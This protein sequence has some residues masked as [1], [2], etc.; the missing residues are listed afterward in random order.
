[1]QNAYVNSLCTEIV[2]F[3]EKNF[4]VIAKPESRAIAGLS[5][6]GGQ[7][8]YT[9]FRHVDMFSS[10]GMFS[11]GLLGSLKKFAAIFA[12]S[13]QHANTTNAGVNSGVSHGP[14]QSGTR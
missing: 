7:T 12:E 14:T 6:G 1:M 8:F 11:S 9:G 10:L 3:I 2:P 4:R 5:M 13:M